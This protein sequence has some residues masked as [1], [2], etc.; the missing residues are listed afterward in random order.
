MRETGLQRAIRRRLEEVLGGYWYKVWGGPY[1]PA[2][3]PDLHGD[4]G[5]RSCWVEVKRPGEDPTEVQTRRMAQL[6]AAGAAVCVARSA[7]EAVDRVREAIDHPTWRF[8]VRC[9]RCTPR[10]GWL[11]GPREYRV[12]GWCSSWG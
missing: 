8:C 4:V 11:Q 2:G 9:E 1:Q 10:L 5:G 3:L 7:A 12:C 6:S